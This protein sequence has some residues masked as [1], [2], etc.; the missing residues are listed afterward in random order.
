MQHS[1]RH[2]REASG[3][4]HRAADRDEIV[5]AKALRQAVGQKAADEKAHRRQRSVIAVI[6]R[7]YGEA[8]DQ[9]RRSA[10]GKDMKARM[11]P[12]GRKRISRQSDGFGSSC[13]SWPAWFWR[14]APVWRRAGY[15]PG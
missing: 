14:K 7:R 12:G 3:D 8:D 2:H 10:G 4:Q 1:E 15:L 13:D 5:D 9:D 11:G 6:L